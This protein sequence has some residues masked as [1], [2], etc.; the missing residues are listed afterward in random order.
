MHPHSGGTGVAGVDGTSGHAG[1]LDR[2]GERFR[3]VHSKLLET[4]LTESERDTL[5]ETFGDPA[6]RKQ[7]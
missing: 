7:W 6:A 4:N 5:L 3:G 1:D 2:L